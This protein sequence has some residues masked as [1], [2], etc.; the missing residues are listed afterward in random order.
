MSETFERCDLCGEHHAKLIGE[1]EGE[2]PEAWA[3][4][5]VKKYESMYLKWCE[6][7]KK[8][9]A[10]EKK[11]AEAVV[12]LRESLKAQ[13]VEDY[14]QDEV[15]RLYDVVKAVAITLEEKEGEE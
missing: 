7:E 1:Q 3:V 10:L 9:D 12:F 11:L 2:C 8:I 4:E 14:A 6:S 15:L 5:Y 13:E